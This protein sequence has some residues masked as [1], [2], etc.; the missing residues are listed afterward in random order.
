M[1]VEEV[2]QTV[3]SERLFMKISIIEVKN[4]TSFGSVNTSAN[5]NNFCQ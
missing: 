2:A 3:E 1:L 4:I 5:V